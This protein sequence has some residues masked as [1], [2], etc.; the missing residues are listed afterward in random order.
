MNPKRIMYELHT[1]WKHGNSYV[2]TWQ[3]LYVYMGIAIYIHGN[4]Y[5]FMHHVSQTVYQPT[6]TIA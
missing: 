2:H 4:G 3:W 5:I 1:C 6:P